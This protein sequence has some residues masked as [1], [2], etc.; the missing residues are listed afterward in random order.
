MDVTKEKQKKIMKCKFEGV[1][2]DLEG[3]ALIEEY[4][5]FIR[6]LEE[7]NQTDFSLSLDEIDKIFDID[8]S[9]WKLILCKVNSLRGNTRYEILVDLENISYKK[10][11]RFIFTFM[12]NIYKFT[13]D[14]KKYICFI[15]E[16]LINFFVGIKEKHG[17]RITVVV[18]G[19]RRVIHP[20]MIS[21]FD[22]QNFKIEKNYKYTNIDFETLKFEEIY[23]LPETIKGNNLNRKL[24]LYTNL[25]EEDYNNFVY[26]DTNERKEF[27]ECLT[28]LF[29]LK[30]Y[31]G[32]CGPFGTGKTITLLKFLIQSD[33]YRVFY[34]NLGTIENNSSEE[35]KNLLKYEAIKL[36]GG[37]I[38]NEKEIF[39]SESEKE[40]YKK[41]IGEIENFN[42]KNIFV[43]LENIIK[44]LN[45]IIDQQKIYIII[46]QYSSKYDE[47]NKS[48]KQLIKSNVKNKNIYFIISSSMNNEDIRNNFSDSLNSNLFNSNDSSILD[49][50]LTY[51]YIGCL[52]R[53][54][55][56]KD[57]D[58]LLKPYGPA[59]IKILNKFGNLPLFFY[60]LKRKSKENG[61]IKQYME[62]EKEIIIEEIELFYEKNSS[63]LDKF[64][65]ILKILS[66]INKREI[67]FIEELSKEILNLPLKFLEIKKEEIIIKDLKIFAFVSKNQK[68]IRLFEEIEK[69]E[70]D[71]KINNLIQNDEY[72]KN[73]THFINADNFCTNY[74]HLISKKKKEKI[75]GDKI[76]NKDNNKITVY[77]LDYLFPYMEEI[78]SSMIYDLILNTSKYI[79]NNLP[80]QTQG[81]FLEYII[82]ENIKKEHSFMKNIFVQDFETIETFVPNN[83]FIQ[84]YSSRKKDTLKTYTEN[85]SFTK[86]KKIILSKCNI[87][88]E[89]SQ[90][91]G[92]YYD[93]CLLIYKK[94]T[95]SYILYL[96]QVSKKKIASNRYYKE[97]HKIIYN[98]VKE[99]LE[100]RYSIKIDEG[101]FSYILL[102][103]EI[104]KKTIEFCEKYSLKYYLF[105][106]EKLCF[107]N[108]QLLFDDICLITKEFPI[109]SSFSILPMESFEINE[110][111]CLT[112]FDDIMKLEKQINFRKVPEEILKILSQYFILKDSSIPVDKNEFLIVGD[113]NDKFDVNYCFCIWLDYKRSTLIYKNKNKKIFEIKL[114]D[115]KESGK[116]NYSLICS[117]YK[118]KY[119]YQK[120]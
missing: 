49:I 69:D 98:R 78:F 47:K 38:F 37:N 93:C 87:F 41:I 79:F 23:S 42:D 14:D 45:E 92:K 32:I 57:Y 114:K 31:I 61:K 56:L 102:S 2:N 120:K 1:K 6:F 74:I 39:C 105:S 40:I 65:D 46:D 86:T 63:V 43:L 4:E 99:N 54:N 8:T 10:K 66:I 28:R 80:A 89:Q 24:G 117:K 72:L 77:Y 7:K 3:K 104:D 101:Y 33:F 88:I 68:L 110:N 113:F 52:I 100:N 35:L 90:F 15:L 48:L 18:G 51:Y 94:E 53:L 11:I 85:K 44:H 25:S 21:Y 22:F 16:S 96:F 50:G 12:K 116:D 26:Y 103:E 112:K 115:Y 119:F 83:F 58:N 36:F 91:T 81:G 62:R 82:N 64:K 71:I 95:D 118:I 75:L 30:N 106:V 17:F 13:Y 34:L 97:E 27:L 109:H 111:R 108:E 76:S 55:N 29:G 59:F 73:L 70:K 67:Y 19:I 5:A 60:E 84:N 20:E 107:E 9:L